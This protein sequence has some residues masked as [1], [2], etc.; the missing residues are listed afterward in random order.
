MY[1]PKINLAS[2][3]NELIAFMQKYSFATIITTN[4]GYP[5][6]THLPFLISERDDK[7]LLTSHFAKANNHWQIIENNIN[8]I[9]FQEPH[10][11]ISPKHYAKELNVPTWNYISVHCYGKGEIIHDEKAV[12]DVL[13]KTILTYE[14]SYKIQYDNLPSDYKTKLSNGIVAFQIEVSDLQGKKKLSQNKTE[15]EQLRIIEELNA[16]VN[17]TEQDIAYYM[18]ECLLHKKNINNHQ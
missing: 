10:A 16:S 6:A 8:L 11:Y 17:S 12:A 14:A 18:K 2:N 9:V 13:E 3:K 7:V 5:V 15:A 1:I 4:D